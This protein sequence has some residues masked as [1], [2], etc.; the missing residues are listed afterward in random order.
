M[1]A[2]KYLFFTSKITIPNNKINSYYLMI[3]SGMIRQLSSGI[4][5]WLP[6]GLRVLKNFKKIIRNEMNNINFFEILMPIIQP[7]SIW[8]TSGRIH[9]YGH[10]LFKIIDRNKRNFFLGPTH[11]EVIT[12][13][14]KHEIKSYK[15]L[16]LNLYQIQ[17]KFR[18]EIRPRLGVVRSKEFL[19]KDGY[20][21]HINEKS[22]KETYNVILNTYKKIFDLIKLKYYVVEGDNSLIGGKISHEF[23]VLSNNG[24]DSIALSKSGYAYNTELAKFFIPVN[25]NNNKNI[26]LK[27]QLL[28]IN[29]SISFEYI[30][31]KFN[32]STNNIIKTIIIKTI[33]KKNPL[34]ALLIRSDYQINTSKIEKLNKN[35]L[36]PLNI[37]SEK[38]I[39]NIFKV[40][41]YS[42]GPINLNIPIIADYSIMT[43]NNFIIGSNI[44]NKYYIN[45]NWKRDL[46]IPEKIQD[47]RKICNRD[48]T[49]DNKH[50]II[51]NKSIEIAHIF[52]LG[53]KYS[54]L[55]NNYIPNI[56]GEKIP[57]HMGCY[58]IGIS[59][60][61]AA[62]IEQN[63]DIH[64]IYWP[65][66]LAPFKVAIIPI[67]MYKYSLIKKVCF[68]IYQKF[69]SIGIEVILDDRKEHP[70][71]MFT[72]IDL[73]G[74]PHIIIIN[75]NNII[76]NNVEYKFRQSGEHNIISVNSIIDFILNK[77]KLN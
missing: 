54:N 55:M 34:I 46:P 47:I 60:I 72:D 58:G 64:G 1:L 49:P 22:L 7:N 17:V 48:F 3:K 68:D 32:S 66:S 75:N 36:K 9:D 26:F 41:S 77:E 40:N 63:H 16:P 62:F 29:K 31:K 5:T 28:S 15:N 38:E 37:L 73:I 30:A 43:M 13:L 14:I 19:M 71:V 18:D 52:Q 57:L 21:F 42:L 12:F 8:E 24:E 39:I 50:P 59:R 74:I 53:T 11:E 70:G 25:F 61:I 65:Y 56:K 2:S 44:Q 4:Y 23:H 10:E 45:I 27:K 69:N 6:T 35:I 33:E 51:I 76:N 20:S 67:N